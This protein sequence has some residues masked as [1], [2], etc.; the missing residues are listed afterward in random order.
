MQRFTDAS[1][2]GR[3]DRLVQGGGF[4]GWGHTGDAY[5]LMGVFA[6]DPQRRHGVVVL[7][8]GPGVDPATFP[9]QW[10]ALYRWEEQALTAVYRR[11]LETRPR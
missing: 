8:T 6:L 11:L 5:G 1:G 3:G 2:P 7:I 9:S 4:T 10:S